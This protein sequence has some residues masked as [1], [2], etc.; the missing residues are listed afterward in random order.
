MEF[1]GPEI[2]VKV[3]SSKAGS[4]SV[5]PPQ[6]CSS[7]RWLPRWPSLRSRGQM[8]ANSSGLPPPEPEPQSTEGF[9]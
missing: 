6:H 1:I 5:I 7:V 4:S 8:A 9:L 2:R 3:R